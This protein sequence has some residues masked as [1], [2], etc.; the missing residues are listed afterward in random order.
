MNAIMTKKRFYTLWGAPLA[1][2]FAM[3]ASAFSTT[4]ARAGIFSISEKEEIKAGQQVRQQAY[5]EYGKPLPASDPMSQR[6]KAIGQKFAKLSE[7]KNIP[8]TYEVLQ[9]DELLNAFAAP[10][11]PV[12][13]TTKLVKTAANDAELAY[14]IGHET[15]HIDRKH[16]IKAVEKQQTVGL[17]VGVI[18]AIFG[19][20]NSDLFQ[21]FGNVTYSLW[22][23]GYSRDQETES[24]VVGARWM[25][26]L[27]FDPNAAISMMGRLGKGSSGISKYLASHPNPEDR[28][29]S[30]RKL[31]TEEKLVDVARRS[32]GPFL[33]LKELPQYS[34]T[35]TAVPSIPSDSERDGQELDWKNDDVR[36]AS[37]AAW[38]N[39]LILVQHD[40]QNTIM[41]PVN[42]ISQ[43]ANAKLEVNERNTNIVT[44]RR[45]N[46]FIRLRRNSTNA[47]LNGKTIRLSAAAQVYNGLLY[48]PLGTLADGVGA[49]AK[50]DEDNSTILLSL[51][52]RYYTADVPRR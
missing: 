5:K 52:E 43:W 13:V 18:G 6:V 38:S 10:G 49:H 40:E 46:N 32:G 2:L 27:G 9:N 44:M 24:D 48:A 20:G 17:G 28:Q 41:A 29:K 7:R 45:G 12:F 51:D 16:I 1:V 11:G 8:Y 3:V 19:I 21:V 23:S 50:L 22:S 14:V 34:Y 25:S 30:V 31:I 36:N 47:V 33:T 42:A 37:R 15:G 26:Q 35:N 4:P 39:Q